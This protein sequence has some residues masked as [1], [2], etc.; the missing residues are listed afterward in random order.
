[1]RPLAQPV[2]DEHGRNLW[3]FSPEG[4]KATLLSE[5]APPS[6]LCPPT[7]ASPLE[8]WVHGLCSWN[9]VPPPAAAESLVVDDVS[10]AS[11][12]IIGCVGPSA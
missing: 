5:Q 12:I 8:P 3:A 11:C 4:L 9:Q 2:C 10:I 1:M 7:G 6:R